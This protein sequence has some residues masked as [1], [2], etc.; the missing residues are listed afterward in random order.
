MAAAA[1]G[2]DEFVP[3]LTPAILAEAVRAGYARA[4][5]VEVA[6]GVLTGAEEEFARELLP[7]YRES[8]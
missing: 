2:L 4:L 1:V 8:F 7:K 3:N 6:E 5:G